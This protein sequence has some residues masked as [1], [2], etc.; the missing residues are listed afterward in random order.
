MRKTNI[1]LLWTG[2]CV[3]ICIAY[4]FSKVNRPHNIKLRRWK[5]YSL[6]IYSRHWSMP[7]KMNVWCHKHKIHARLFDWTQRHSKIVM[8]GYMSLAV[9]TTEVLKC[10]AIISV[11]SE[12]T[13]K[14]A[15][16]NNTF[17]TGNNYLKFVLYIKY[18]SIFIP[19]FEDN[20]K[21]A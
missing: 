10:R 3:T 13:F 11:S 1:F 19:W 8:Q 7:M 6:E 9:S 18:V 5:P 12:Q 17:N 4:L 20:V 16:P 15:S 21:V 2:K 14:T